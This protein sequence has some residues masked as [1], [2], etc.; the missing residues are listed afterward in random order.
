M[1]ILEHVEALPPDPIF[2][3]GAII[4]QDPRECKVDLTVGIYH[5]ENLQTVTME[6]VKEAEKR[7]LEVEKNKAYLPMGGKEDFVQSSRALVFGDEFAKSECKRFM[8][9]QSLG[10]TNALRIGGEILSAEVTKQIY[11]SDPT[12]PNHPG[13]FK[14]CG[15]EIKTYP[16]YNHETHSIDF[17]RMLDTLAKAPERSTVL[18]HA[19]CHNPTGCDL[20]KEQWKEL[21]TFMLKRKL[22]PFFDFAYQ[23]F[24]QGVEEDAWPIR[25]F[26]EMGHELFVAH[27][28]SKFFGL[29]GERT[30]ALHALV[31]DE[32]TAKRSAT[33]L[34]QVIRECFSNPPRHGASLV[35]IIMRDEKLKQ[36]WLDELTDMRH[37]INEM[38]GE[39][40][41]ALEHKVG[42]NK[43]GF[44]K[45]RHGLFSMLGLKNEIV[46]QLVEKYGLYLTQ[47][48]RIN[49]SGL[50]RKN[51]AYVV[52]AIVDIVNLT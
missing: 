37:R 34:K 8:G 44:L 52:D 46:D 15:M 41:D 13:I 14:A 38:R 49:L 20:E 1:S 10:G 29:Y 26:A 16:Y 35:A 18:L 9:V 19:C 25:H 47:S 27:S 3:L 5:N 48:G 51:V 31:K 24:A 7:L 23:G 32:G 12:W 2:G 42:T 33:V 11:M 6:A 45:N 50:N 22:I 17:D 43:F 30:G 21:C 40:V 4:K 36:M 39:F 28:F